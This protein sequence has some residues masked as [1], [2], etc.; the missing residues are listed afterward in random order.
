MVQHE[1]ITA[2]GDVTPTEAL[3]VSGACPSHSHEADLAAATPA[4]GAFGII[5]IPCFKCEVLGSLRIDPDEIQWDTD[6]AHIGE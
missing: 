5:D 2:N 3:C 4:D 1:H 6:A